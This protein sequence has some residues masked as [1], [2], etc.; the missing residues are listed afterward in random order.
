MNA[1]PTK[2]TISVDPQTD[3]NL[4]T[5]LAQNGMKKG[6]LSKFVEEAVNWRLIR[7]TVSDVQARFSDLESDDIES[8]IEE[9]VA[10]ARSPDGLASDKTARDE[11]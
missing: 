8:L 7:Q 3:I 11:F 4:R 1:V 6:D 10:W 2:W 9:A 5:H